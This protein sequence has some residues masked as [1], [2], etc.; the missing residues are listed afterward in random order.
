MNDQFSLLPNI[1]RLIDGNG[2]F[3][4]GTVG[5]IR[6]AATAANDDQSLA[7]LIRRNGEILEQ[8]LVRA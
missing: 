3:T 2:E 5:R 6:C 7:M 8:L 1:E 4:I